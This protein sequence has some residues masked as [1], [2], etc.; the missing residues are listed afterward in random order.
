MSPSVR[1]W[2]LLGVTLLLGICLGVLGGGALQE[3]RVA[4][5]NDIRRPS[6]FL[7]H[8]HDVI[9]P[10]SDSQW[11][12]IRP[13]V[14]A[15]AARN[16]GMRHVHDSAMRATLDSLRAQLNPMLDERQRERLSRFAPDAAGR[17]PRAR[18]GP[19]NDGPGPKPDRDDRRDSPPPP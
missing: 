3:R 17:R 1:A 18:G 15:T 5:V 7:E 9:E 8:M 12:I 16:M 13:L 10:V 6:G 4:R 19:R 14:E 11:A 2:V